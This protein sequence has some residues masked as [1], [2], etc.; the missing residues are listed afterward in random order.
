MKGL[1]VSPSVT[2]T[3]GLC[4]DTVRLQSERA[5]PGVAYRDE[6]VEGKPRSRE[7]VRLYGTNFEELLFPG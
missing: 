6:T 5:L 1:E 3:R 2:S 4:R 7:G